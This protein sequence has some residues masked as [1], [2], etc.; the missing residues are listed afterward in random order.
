MADVVLEVGRAWWGRSEAHLH[1]INGGVGQSGSRE[2][3]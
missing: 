2:I 3:R 1:A